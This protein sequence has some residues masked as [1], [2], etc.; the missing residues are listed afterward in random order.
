[1]HDKTLHHVLD[2]WIVKSTSDTRH[3]FHRLDKCD[4]PTRYHFC[5]RD[6]DKRVLVQPC[7]LVPR[8]ATPRRWFRNFVPPICASNVAVRVM[9]VPIVLLVFLVIPILPRLDPK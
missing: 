7:Q 3:M 8:Y 2:D 1:M 4:T 9:F 6:V 5:E